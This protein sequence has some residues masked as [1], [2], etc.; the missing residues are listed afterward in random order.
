M[1]PSLHGKDSSFSSQIKACREEYRVFCQGRS[2]L[3][4]YLDPRWLDT[5]CGTQGWSAAIATDAAGVLTF[6]LPFQFG[7]RYRLFRLLH[8][9]LF[10]PY[11]GP[12]L[13]EDPVKT[14]VHAFLHRYQEQVHQAMT[15]W[16]RVRFIR[17]KLHY[18]IPHDLPFR[19]EGMQNKPRV[20]HLIQPGET[21]E[22][23]FAALD[24][25]MQRDIRQAQ[26]KYRIVEVTDQEA[27]TRQA[28]GHLEERRVGNLAAY[29]QALMN[30]LG[31]Y[32]GSDRLQARLAVDE[33]GKT[34]AGA[35]FV[36]DADSVYYLTAFRD[37][38]ISNNQGNSLLVWQGI[39][40]ALKTGRIFDF[41]G[42]SIPGVAT[43][44]KRFGAEQIQCIEVFRP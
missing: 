3:P 18:T 26:R 39:E 17:W 30:I 13:A 9:P 28:I 4:L 23:H 10:T 27:F 25:K 6:A 14:T 2:D 41:E 11:V 35:L 19:W 12:F 34:V 24:K 8:T 43:Y 20:T 15:R 29:R 22:Q 38:R 1:D 32:Q 21:P 40:W 42:S 5:V 33:Q 7:Y 37:T 16:R 36:A 31:E 44:F